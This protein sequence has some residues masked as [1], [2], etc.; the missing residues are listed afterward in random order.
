MKVGLHF[1]P[2][3]SIIQE[4]IGINVGIWFLTAAEQ[5]E[6]GIFSMQ[7]TTGKNLMPQTDK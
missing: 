7:M 5:I 6:A 1:L 3:L 4:T 2:K